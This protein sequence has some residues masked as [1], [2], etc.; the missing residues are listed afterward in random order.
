MVKVVISKNDEWT[1][2]QW[3]ER[4]GDWLALGSRNKLAN[5]WDVGTYQNKRLVIFKE[6]SVGEDNNRE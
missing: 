2:A 6:E 3:I 1:R 4:K 5:W